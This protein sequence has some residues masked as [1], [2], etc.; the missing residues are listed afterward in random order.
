[1]QTMLAARY[2][3]PD[4]L[5]PIYTRRDFEAAIALAPSLPL[6]ERAAAFERFRARDGVCKIVIEPN[7]Y[8]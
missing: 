2:L 6:P 7:L 5:A 1:M 8:A 4:R 3:G